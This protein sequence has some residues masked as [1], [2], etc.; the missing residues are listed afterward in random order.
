[1]ARHV[2]KVR[3]LLPPD[4]DSA[5][6]ALG[7][8]TIGS[9]SITGSVALLSP[10]AL[11]VDLGGARNIAAATPIRVE[12]F[13]L[14]NPP[15]GDHQLQV[16]TLDLHNHI[17]ET[18]P[19]IAFA[20]FAGSSSDI[21]A[22]LAGPG[23]TGG[24]TSGDATLSVDT[25]VIQQ[26]ISGVC[27]AGNAIRVINQDG[28]VSCAGVAGAGGGT[29]T[30]VGT[31]A[32]LTGGPITTTGTV[33]VAPGGITT[34]LLADGSV[35]TS[36]L[37][38]G[39]V[40]GAKLG[41]NSVD[42]SKIVDGSVGSADVN[43][44]QIQLR[45]SGTCAAGNAIRVVNQDGTVSCQSLGSSGGVANVT[46]SAPLQSSGG[47]TPAISLPNVIIG[48]NTAI[49]LNALSR[50]TAGTDNTAS[51]AGALAS[52]TEGF[53]NT[54]TGSGALSLNTRGSNNTAFGTGTLAANTLGNN[55]TAVGI[56][57]LRGSTGD[58]NTAVGSLALQTGTSASGNTAIGASA[59]TAN[60]TGNANTAVGQNA[61]A[62]NQDGSEN[63]AVG[64]MALQQ[65]TS[66]SSNTAV[67]HRALAKN[68]STIITT[69]SG[70]TVIVGAQNTAI[71]AAALGSNTTGAYNTAGGYGALFNN[72]TGD[73]NTA[74]GASALSFNTTGLQN[75]A[76]GAD[77]LGLNETGHHNTASGA[78]ALSRNVDGDDNTANGVSA[79]SANTEG[80]GNTASGTE[81]LLNNNKGR[82][83]TAVGGAALRNNTTGV[84]NT[85]IGSGADV[86]SDNLT[87]ATAIG[88]NAKANGNHQMVLGDS[89]GAPRQDSRRP[90]RRRGDDV[91]MCRQC[92][93]ERRHRR[94]VPVGPETQEEHQAVR[95]GARAA[96][97]APPHVLPLEGRGVSG[98][99][100]RLG[101]KLRAHRPGRRGC[102][103]R[104]GHR[105]AR[106]LQG[107]A[108]QHVA[109][110]AAPGAQRQQSMI[111]QRRATD[112]QRMDALEAENRE[113]RAKLVDLEQ[114][115][116]STPTTTASVRPAN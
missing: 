106:R 62:G 109:P 54:A 105:G 50:N 107:G 42:S 5:H 91:G 58:S 37:P 73:H 27:A 108:L 57:A 110:A 10:D 94:D 24:A 13:N 1:M 16:S 59:L 18:F 70:L 8:I 38:D 21:T 78:D 84:D 65:N 93:R 99:T 30:S 35:A 44:G 69:G 71:G 98:A 26:R 4:T 75:T 96:G 66:G 48:V 114:L 76:T 89:P 14:K 56:L 86:T 92:H 101:G 63:T 32:G 6:A 95:P 72:I 7:R 68:T 22:V 40:T 113:L 31:G 3:I 82:F 2:A 100:A 61:L 77:A 112:G 45:V 34:G 9:T 103:S 90:A 47:S 19:P 52:N 87:N 81:A 116:R 46:A 64:S 97:P 23:L 88:A 28:T 17:L 39:A 67:G 85:A 43:A 12:L 33:A 80:F 25:A 20:S 74:F 60:S 115:L 79:L 41:A 11:L 36:K 55:N 29:V 53:S 111:E 51:G 15:A 49:G 104:N 102:D 83:N